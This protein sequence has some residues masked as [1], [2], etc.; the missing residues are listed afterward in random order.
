MKTAEEWL[1]D[2][3]NKHEKYLSLDRVTAHHFIKQIQ[4][5]AWKQGMSDAAAICHNSVQPQGPYFSTL[6]K[7][8]RDTKPIQL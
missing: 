7:S 5:N 8:G 1:A 4:L 2:H 3:I 6:V